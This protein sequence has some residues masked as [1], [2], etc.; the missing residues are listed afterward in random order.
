M[1][2][3]SENRTVHNTWP[4]ILTMYNIS[5]WLCYERKYLMLTILIQVPKQA[6]INIDVFLEPVMEDMAKLW[7]ERLRMWDQY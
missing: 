4:V 5:T 3:F 6:G 2:S 1:N 7:N